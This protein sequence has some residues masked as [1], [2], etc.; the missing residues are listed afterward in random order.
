MHLTSKAG[1]MRYSGKTVPEES[2]AWG[3]LLPVGGAP[4]KETPAAHGTVVEISP[5]CLRLQTPSDALRGF[6][7]VGTY[8]LGVWMTFGAVFFMV[9]FDA[10]TR[11]YDSFDF[12][13][14]SALSI[15]LA[16][17]GLISG[18]KLTFSRAFDSVIFSRRLRRIYYWEKKGGWKSVDYDRAAAFVPKLRM[19]T[20]TG[21][22]VLY[23]LRVVEFLPGTRRVNTG[24][25]PT[26]PF[27]QPQSAAQLWEFIR[28][29]MDEDPA[30]LPPVALLP[31]HR[32]NAYAWMDRELFP[33][34]SG[35][36]ASP[37]RYIRG[38]VILVLRVRLL[39][40][41][42]VGI[43]DSAAWQSAG[44]AAG[45]GRYLGVGRRESLSHHPFHAGGAIGDRGQAA[46]YEEALARG[47]CRG[48]VHL[49]G[50]AGVVH[51][52]V[53]AVYVTDWSGDR[54]WGKAR[55]GR[56]SPWSR[57]K[58]G[59]GDGCSRSRPRQR[60][61]RLRHFP[62]VAWWKLRPPACG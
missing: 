24:V 9:K 48:I 28:C 16:L 42:L 1:S 27:A 53:R 14:V 33:T 17:V 12:I 43:L 30:A 51:G 15:A 45:A 61:R 47:Q 26:V 46:S 31:D 57:T 20:A 56:A 34:V 62:T 40:A 54:Q 18:F 29:Y 23:P 49:G 50:A 55:A 60:A 2:G 32:A 10:S 22:N 13:L 44:V 11:G 3:W 41:E 35:Q 58:A 36:A 19:T 37:E 52:G 6:A 8:A 21:S 4:R 39:R 59:H 25:S 5:A 38:F 7:A